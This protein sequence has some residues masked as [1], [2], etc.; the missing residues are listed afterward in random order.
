MFIYHSSL[1]DFA[2]HTGNHNELIKNTVLL[3]LILRDF[4]FK[5]TDKD[6]V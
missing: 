2:G 4:F 6:Y 5:I 1:R 3:Q